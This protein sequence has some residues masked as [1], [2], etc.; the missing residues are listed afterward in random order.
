M[1]PEEL[2]KQAMFGSNAPFMDDDMLTASHGYII[3]YPMLVAAIRDAVKAEREACAAL[4]A[5]RYSS[6]GDRPT[7]AELAAA[8]RGRTP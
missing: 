3:N 7:I 5:G 1:T 2:A 6:D 8:I 4:V